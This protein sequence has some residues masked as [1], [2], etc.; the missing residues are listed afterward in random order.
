MPEDSIKKKEEANK[1]KNFFK[2]F[3]ITNYNWT[4]M[5]LIHALNACT[6]LL[7]FSINYLL[8][9]KLLNNSS[10]FYF[11]KF[12]IEP[13]SLELEDLIQ[14]MSI[15]LKAQ[16]DILI[17]SKMNNMKIFTEFYFSEESKSLL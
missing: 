1:N 11:N 7:I 5:I 2:I 4:F 14:E 6:I 13:I 3:G 10:D 15:R 8:I 16:E 12:I 9:T 17:E